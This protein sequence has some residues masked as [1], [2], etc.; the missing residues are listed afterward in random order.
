[1][2]WC[3]VFH[4][5]EP[6]VNESL[7]AL[8]NLCQRDRTRAVLVDGFAEQTIPYTLRRQ[9]T[10]ARLVKTD[11]I[12]PGRCDLHHVFLQRAQA[13]CLTQE[14]SG[15]EVRGL[16][17]GVGSAAGLEG[18]FGFEFN[19]ADRPCARLAGGHTTGVAGIDHGDDFVRTRGDFLCGLSQ[20]CVGDGLSIVGQQAFHAT[21]D[22]WVPIPRAV[23]GKVDEAASAIP[24]ALSQLPNFLEDSFFGGLLVSHQADLVGRNAH[25]GGNPFGALHVM[26]YTFERG[27]ASVGSVLAQTDDHCRTQSGCL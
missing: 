19:A 15:F 18:E 9:S 4:P 13:C 27:C 8:L 5:L 10:F 2:V 20:L 11:F 21:V 3:Q 24:R 26:G 12:R 7:R 14:A 22:R 17:A 1:M 6:R 25:G 23:S 16:A